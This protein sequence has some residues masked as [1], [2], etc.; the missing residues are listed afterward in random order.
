MKQKVSIPLLKDHH[1]H[2]SFYALFKDCLNLQEIKDK[3]KALQMAQSLDRDRISVVLGWNTG[4]YSFSEEELNRFP[5]VIIVNLSLHSFIIN[6]PAEAEL[7]KKYPDIIANYKDPSWYEAHFSR[8]LIFLAD[9]VEPTEQKIKTLFDSLYEKGVYYAEDML[10]TGE[11][12]YS[13]IN[14]SPYRG[15]TAFWADLA[16]FK[17][18]NPGVQRGVKGIKL[19]AD[20]ALGAGTAALDIPYNNG[21]KAG[22]LHTDDELFRQMQEVAILGKG[23]SVHA[24]GDKALFQVVRTMRKLKSGGISFPEVRMEHCQ[25]I[26]EKTAHEAKELGIILSM[27][28]NFSDDSTV[29]RDR[30]P[31]QYLEQNNPFRMLIDKAGFV[32]GKDL[33]FGSDGMPHGM[34]TALQTSLFPPFP[35]QRLTLDEFIAGYCMPD[36]SYGAME[37]EIDDS[38]GV[39][40]CIFGSIS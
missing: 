35:Q 17:I 29:Y 2:P 18:L 38:S 8:M 10:L 37:I 7:K 19:F 32:P 12:A 30:L 20:G 24:I 22:L 26:N 16:T 21:K 3:R 5:P 1:N 9:M 13:I 40:V 14:S 15:R 33:I 34:K 25:F 27:Q 4:F 23:V 31:A 28:P 6:A 39:R 11:K 36:K